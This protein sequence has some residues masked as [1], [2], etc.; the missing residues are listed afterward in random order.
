MGRERERGKERESGLLVLTKARWKSKLAETFV[1]PSTNNFS[2]TVATT[3]N[4]PPPPLHP[5][6]LR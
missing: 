2:S 6:M 1:N 5:H 3:A 4:A